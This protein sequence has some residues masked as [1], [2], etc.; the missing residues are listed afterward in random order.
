MDKKMLQEQLTAYAIDVARL[1]SANQKKDLELKKLQAQL[2]QYATDFRSTVMDLKKANS[3]LQDAYIE[4][5]HRLAIAAEYKDTDTGNHIFRVSRYS[6]LL[7]D[8]LG[9]PAE[10]RQNIS[11]A[12]PMHDIGKIGIPDEIL[13]KPSKLTFAEFEIMKTHTTIGA[14]ILTGS[15]SEIIG[16]AHQIALT[17]HEKWDG[18]GYPRQLKGEEI[19][20][21]GRIVGLVDCFD[22]L[23][24]K[25]PYKKAFSLDTAFAIIREDSGKHFDPQ[26][27]E[28]FC[29]NETAV[30]T[31][32]FE[33]TSE[34]VSELSGEE[35]KNRA[36][37]EFKKG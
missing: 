26:L 34:D 18:T 23:T 35:Y 37:P 3:D 30:F 36:A 32:Y 8:L 7:S 29:N 17:H 13:C 24:M 27:V 22:A 14:K 25:R 28:L 6:Q 1:V 10:T 9:L 15:T 33:Y 20:L 21:V 16:I 5:I 31:I 12:A 19:P 11:Y 2:L 4:T